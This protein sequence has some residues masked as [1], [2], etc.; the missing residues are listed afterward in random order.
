MKIFDIISTKNIDE[1][2]EWFDKNIYF[3]NTPWSHWWDENYC[4]KCEGV[5]RTDDDGHE[6]DY[7]YCELHGNC[8]YF[9]EMNDIPNDK[10]II[11]MWLN[12]EVDDE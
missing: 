10:E 12:T 3:D 7:A 2:A 11:K 5:I 8:K 9:K 4:R 1:L 6:R